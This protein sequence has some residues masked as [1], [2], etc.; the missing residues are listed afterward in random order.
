MHKV[1]DLGFPSSDRTRRVP[2][3]TR[4]VDHLLLDPDPA[5]TRRVPPWTRRFDPLDLG[6]SFPFLVFLIMGFT[7]SIHDQSYI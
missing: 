3:P 7:H 5:R 1:P 4:R 2:S 6:I